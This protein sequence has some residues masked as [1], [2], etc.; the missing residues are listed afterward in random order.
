M[1]RPLRV[2]QLQRRDAPLVSCELLAE[3]T[4]LELLSVDEAWHGDRLA[5][6]RQLMQ[7]EIPRSQWPQSLHWDWSRK[8]LAA[9]QLIHSV[10]AIRSESKWLGAMLI[11]ADPRY[12]V[13]LG[14]EAGKEIVY[15]DFVESAPWNWPVPALDQDVSIT[16]VGTAL[17]LAAV[18]KSME[19]EFGGRLGLHALPQSERF[20]EAFGMTR[21]AADA[22]KQGLVYFEMTQTQAQEAWRKGGWT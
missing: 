8:V 19:E 15:V 18:E 21:V 14:P 12:R 3:L 11:R 17:M 5:M 10:Y 13:R 2:I 22:W 7:R 6:M 20:Y 4:P 1:S 9:P 16:G